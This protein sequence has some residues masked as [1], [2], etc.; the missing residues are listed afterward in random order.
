MNAK[1]IAQDALRR[2]RRADNLRSIQRHLEEWISEAPE[3]ILRSARDGDAGA[4]FG[5]GFPPYLG[6]PFR[7]ADAMGAEEVVRRLERLS[8]EYGRR[9]EPAERLRELAREGKAFYP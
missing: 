1:T 2:R 4:I 9:F 6:G 7:Y 8:A 5:L 3:G